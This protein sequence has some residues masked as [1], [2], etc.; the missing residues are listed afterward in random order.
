MTEAR[1]DPPT[2]RWKRAWPV[3][4][5]LLTYAFFILVVGLLVGLA[6]NVDWSEVATTLRNYSAGT[7]LLAGAATLTSYAVYCCYDVLGKRYAR[8]DLPV[9]QIIPVTFVCYA[10]NLNLSAW[11]GGIALRYRLYSRLGLG[12]SQ[13]TSVFTL[14]ILTNWLGYLWLAGLIF[15]MGWISPPADWE[16]GQTALR[17]LGFGLL[18]AAAVYLLACGISKRRHWTI[19][20]HEIHLP[21]LRLAVFQMLLGAANW[22]LMALVV[23]FMLSQ[24]APYPQVL[25]ILMIS[26]MAGVLAHIPAGLG[27]IEAV[28]AAMLVDQMSQGAIVGGLIGYRVVY[29]LIPLMFATLVYVILE[30]RAKKLRSGNQAQSDEEPQPRRTA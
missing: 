30:A 29:F 2:S 28:F 17:A 10:F 3:I 20:Q 24:K 22:S 8:H 7:L 4:K 16:I 1:H 26:S 9:R 25:G 5:K 27:V 18:L 11:V 23:Y 6:R 19:R 15:A 21:S 14:S 12:A 13:I